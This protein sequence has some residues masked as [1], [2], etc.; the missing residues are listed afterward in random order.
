[1][2]LEVPRKPPARRCISIWQGM[3]LSGLIHTAVFVAVLT[4]AHLLAG[5]APPRPEKENAPSTLALDINGLLAPDQM[6]EKQLQEKMGKA[7]RKT[8]AEAASQSQKTVQNTPPEPAR[9]QAEHASPE[10]PADKAPP[11]KDGMPPPT[12]QATT[13]PPQHRP[14]PTPTQT[15]VPRHTDSSFGAVN[16]VG[17]EQRQ[18]AHTLSRDEEKE[19]LRNY[20]RDLGKKIRTRL[21]YPASARDAHLVG[22]TKVAFTILASGQL[23]PG[24]LH[25]VTSSGMPELDEWALETVRASTP[26]VPPPR[27]LSIAIN[28]SF[29][30]AKED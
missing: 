23:C 11:D 5:Q 1:M 15:P 20:I 13:S 26:F 21:V 25:V 14:L 10:S 4:T 29:E 18:A 22:A 12:R 2:T 24:T 27:Q 6:Q 30:H 8:P 9:P 17:V 3:I 28:V 19:R 7:D 16:R